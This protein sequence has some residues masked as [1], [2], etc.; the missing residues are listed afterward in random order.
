MMGDFRDPIAQALL[1]KQQQ[2]R[3]PFMPQVPGQ[4]RPMPPAPMMGTPAPR[5]Q[6][7]SPYGFQSGMNAAMGSRAPEDASKDHGWKDLYDNLTQG[8]GPRGSEWT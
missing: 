6:E 4:P 3:R 8:F 2:Q 7:A 1:L 5:P